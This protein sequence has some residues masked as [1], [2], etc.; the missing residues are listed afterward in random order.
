MENA[1]F[2]KPPDRRKPYALARDR[3]GIYYFVDRSD[4]P[5]ARDF[6]LYRGPKGNLKQLQMTNIVLDSK[7]DIFST[8]SGD[9]RLVLEKE[10]SFWVKGRKSQPLINIPVNDNLRMIYN[11]LGVYIGVR[12]G[13]PCDD[14]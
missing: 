1:T 11:E 12:L 4:K 10:N 6:R 14:L 8:K 7:G 3:K 2:G 5:D 13:T 9:L